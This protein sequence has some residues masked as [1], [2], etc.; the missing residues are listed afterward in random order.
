MKRSINKPA[1]AAA[2]STAAVLAVPAAWIATARTATTRTATA[3]TGTD[4]AAHHTAAAPGAAQSQPRGQGQPSNADP[5][6]LPEL[7]PVTQREW[8]GIVEF[9]SEYMPFRMDE[10]ERMPDGPTK[11]RVKRLLANRFRGLRLLQNRDPESYEARLGQLRLEDQVYK[12]VSG[13]PGSDLERR[14]KIRDELRVQVEKLVDVDLQERK[15]RVERLEEELA[16]QKKLLEQDSAERDSLVDRR[17]GRFLDWGNRW[18]A[19]RPAAPG[20]G[21]A[22]ADVNK[23]PAARTPGAAQPQQRPQSADK[24]DEG[25]EDDS[26]R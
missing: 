26:D 12:L 22:A 14:Q 5:R 9:M 20:T 16:R 15:R 6:R 13:L 17:V 4:R 24:S 8:R 7:R 1:V 19:Q 10:V 3:R 21:P 2:L 23:G 11:E 25:A 18:P